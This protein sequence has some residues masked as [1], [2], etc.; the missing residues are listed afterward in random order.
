VLINDVAS[1]E[2]CAYLF[3]FDSVFGPWREEVPVPTRRIADRRTRAIRFTNVGDI[4]QLDLHGVDVLLECTGQPYTR[5]YASRGLEAGA[6][7]VLISGPAEAADMTLILGANEERFDGQ[8]IVS[9][10]SCTTNALA[11]LLK[12]VDEAYG[13]IGGQ[14]TTVHCYT[15]SQPTVD[16][17]RDDFARSRAAALSMVP[18]STSAHKLLGKVLPQLAGKIEARAIRVPTASVSAIDLTV[19]VRC[20]HARRSDR[21]PQAWPARYRRSL[22]GLTSRWSRSICGRG[23]N[24]WWFRARKPRCRREGCCAC[25][26]GTTTSGVSPTECWMLPPSAMCEHDIGATVQRAMRVDRMIDDSVFSTP[27]I[28]PM[29]SIVASSSLMDRA[30]T[31]AI[32]SKLPLTE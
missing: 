11:P 14:M 31:M 23:R 30:A 24:H 4:G 12:L 1:L 22:D 9:N 15:G 8:T 17:P 16:Q 18:T 7:R 27:S 13:V 2:S 29:L 6:R 21:V 32:M 25:S 20:A 28:E 5:A 19:V 26:A 10:G 3:Q